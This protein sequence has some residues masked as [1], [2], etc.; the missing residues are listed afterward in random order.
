MFHS[1]ELKMGQWDQPGS[2]KQNNVIFATKN[3]QL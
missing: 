2:E 1:D 3:A